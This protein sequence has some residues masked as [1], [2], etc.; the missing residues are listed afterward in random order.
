M[1]ML[2]TVRGVG[3][4]RRVRLRN[5]RTEELVLADLVTLDNP[6]IVDYETIWQATLREYEEADQGFSWRFKQRLVAHHENY[7]GYALEYDNLTQGLMLIET[8]TR[9]SRFTPG[10]RLVAVEA[11]ATA[12][13]NRTSIQRPRDLQGVGSALLTFARERSNALGYQGRVGLYSLPEAVRFY[14]R[15]GMT[16]LELEPEEILD[17]EDMTPYFE[18]V[19]FPAVSENDRDD[20]LS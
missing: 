15:Q 7:E 10:K 8:Q 12:P 5:G 11:L 2:I 18:Y 4:I 17:D 9:W 1:K 19:V 6:H 3:F 16:R 14:E 13:W 20:D